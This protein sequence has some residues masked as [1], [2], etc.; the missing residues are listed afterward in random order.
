[1]TNDSMTVIRGGV[2]IY[3][4]TTAQASYDA[5]A[6]N[7]N[8]FG[9]I[10]T[11]YSS[12]ST[13]GSAFTLANGL[14]YAPTQPLGTG[15]GQTAFL[16]QT[17]YYVQ[18]TA[19]DPQSQQYTLTLSRELPSQTVLDISYLG[20]HG[21]HFMLPSTYSL[22]QLDPK[23]FSLGTAYL[24]ALVPNPYAGKVPGTL[25][26]ATI[27]RRNLMKPYP[28]MLD[29]GLSYPRDAHFDGNFLY[30]S[31]RRRAQHGFQVLGAYTYGK[32]MDLPIYTDLASTAGVQTG[33]VTQNTR[34]IDAEYTV[35]AFDVTHRGTISA[36]YDLP[37]GRGQRFVSH[38]GVLNLLVEGFQF[39]VIMTAESGRPLGVTGANQRYS[40]QAKL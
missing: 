18:P 37:L 3:Y 2:A 4:P 8:G 22:N 30:V 25:G 16:G 14:P 34:N 27:S 21:I 32:L 31:A 11:T 20:N 40:D 5:A 15:G 38:S 33:S 39:N 1:L 7:A 35:D 36:M 9:T 26:L 24:N 10:T 17:A 19:K 23:Y 13:N 28:Y 29:V 6:G 12:A